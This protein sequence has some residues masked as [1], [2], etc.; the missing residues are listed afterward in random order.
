M[1]SPD[2]YVLE[3]QVGFVMRRAVQRHIAIS[4]P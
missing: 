2:N 3:R 1:E 4:R